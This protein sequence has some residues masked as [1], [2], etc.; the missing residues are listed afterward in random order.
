MEEDEV[1]EIN[2]KR[3]GLKAHIAHLESRL[4]FWKGGGR[5]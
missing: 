2:W 1:K 3:A 4:Q 5:R